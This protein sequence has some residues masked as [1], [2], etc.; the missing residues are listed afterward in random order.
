[1]VQHHAS[2]ITGIPSPQEL[3]LSRRSVRYMPR[4]LGWPLLGIAYPASLSPRVASTLD[5]LIL[6]R[7]LTENHL[8]A[9]LPCW[10]QCEWLGEFR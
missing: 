3:A 5:L 4:L 6:G 9:N 7:S 8:R 1:M 10:K 2:C